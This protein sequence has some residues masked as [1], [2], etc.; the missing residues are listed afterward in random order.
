[1]GAQAGSVLGTALAIKMVAYV[2]LAPIANAVSEFLP[3]RAT[4]VALDVIR[5]AIV[6]FL[7]FVD[8]VWQIYLL[9]FLLQ[10]ASAAFTPAFQATIPDL[11]PDEAEYTQ[12][13]SLSR[14]AYDLENLVSPIVAAA[15]LG[16]VSFHALFGVTVLGFLGSALLVATVALPTP[17]GRRVRVAAIARITRGLRIYLATPRLRG[18][19]ALSM[20]AAAAGAAV[21]V[22]TVIVVQGQLGLDARHTAFAFASFGGGSMIAALALPRLLGRFSDRTVMLWA[23]FALVAGL[24]ACSRVVSFEWL[25]PAWL[26]MGLAYGAV[27]TPAG[28]LVV[29]SALS[30]DRRAVFAAQ[31][32]LSHACWLV[33]YPLAGRYGAA[34]GVQDAFIVLAAVA[35]VAAVVGAWL[36]PARES[37]GVVHEHRDLHPEHP[38]LRDSRN[39]GRMHCHAI[40]GDPLHA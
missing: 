15:A 18:L 30:S 4:M 8:Q 24:A 27:Q 3:R 40:A 7:P 2:G 20:V 37:A 22:N 11:V 33:A 35:A 39:R 36:W 26:G 16:V 12:A 32:S 34:F 13:L 6:A 31:F 21:I 23:G 28:R 9:I 19:L 25:L 5:A 1:A 38:H 29:R 14:L 10:S 17:A